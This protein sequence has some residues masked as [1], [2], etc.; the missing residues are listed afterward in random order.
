MDDLLIVERQLMPGVPDVRMGRE[1]G[2]ESAIAPVY[3]P[4]ERGGIEKSA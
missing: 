4:G 3:P 1:T 2:A